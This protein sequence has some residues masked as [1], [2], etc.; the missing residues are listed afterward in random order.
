MLEQEYRSLQRLM[1]I[2][3]LRQKGIQDTHLLDWNF[4]VAEDTPYVQMGKRYVNNWQQVKAEN[5]GLLFWGDVG[6]GKS[7]LAACIANGLL[8]QGVSVM[9][10]NFTRILNKLSDLQIKERSQFIAAFGEVDLLIIDETT[11]AL[12]TKG[13][14]LIYNL[15]KRMHEENK[16]VLF[17]SHD[18]SVVE[19]IS[20][21]VGVMYLGNLVEYGAKSDI[22]RNPL[23]PYT[24]ALFSAIPVPDPTVKMNRIVLEGSIP[25]PANPPKG[26]K[27]HTRCAN[28]MKRCEEE[29]PVQREIE[30][31]HFV[32]CHLYD[33]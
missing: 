32:C 9:M 31:G 8:D 5:L 18:L 11:T 17:I 29:A 28:C 33:K 10:T 27:F 19:H 16:A 3:E 12:A 21:T 2:A 7:F 25:S 4:R 24:K 1:E 14:R 6:T 30:P 26:C 15:I 22:F 23:H 20:D 13:R